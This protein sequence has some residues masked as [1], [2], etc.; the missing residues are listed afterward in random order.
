MVG[1]FFV[2]MFP[3]ITDCLFRVIYNYLH[4]HFNKKIKN[5]PYKN[6]PP[7]F[8][9]ILGIME[10]D[11]QNTGTSDSSSQMISLHEGSEKFKSDSLIT[12]ESSPL[13]ITNDRGLFLLAPDGNMQLRILGSIRFSA[14]YDMVEMPVKSSF[15]TYYIPTG[16]DNIKVPNYYNSLNES[17]LGFEV[18]RLVGKTVVFGRLETDFNGKGGQFRI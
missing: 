13:D 9:I 17:R 6:T 8:L 10:I 12:E 2:P 3:F 7:K 18:K 15:N 11:A 1:L 16:E 4:F 14:L 5:V